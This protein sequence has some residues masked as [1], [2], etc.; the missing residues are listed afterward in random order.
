MIEEEAPSTEKE[1]EGYLDR[2]EHKV[3]TASLKQ[4]KNC[5]KVLPETLTRKD[6]MKLSMRSKQTIENLIAFAKKLTKTLQAAMA[7]QADENQNV[8]AK[9]HDEA[10]M[11]EDDENEHEDEYEGEEG[12]NSMVMDFYTNENCVKWRRGDE[13]NEE[14]ERRM[15]AES[16]MMSLSSEVRS[17]K[18]LK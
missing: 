17:V 7:K 12:M 3:L 6:I 16:G 9:V 5:G 1:M 8:K 4:L 10:A 15:R 13:F 18:L 2:N 11:E 14:N